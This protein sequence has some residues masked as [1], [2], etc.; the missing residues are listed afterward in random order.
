M[1]GLVLD[2]LAVGHRRGRRRPAAAVLAGVDARAGAG[3]LTVLVG[4]NGT[5]KSTLLHTVAGLLPPLAGTVRVDGA[6]VAELPPAERARR[7]AVVLTERVE[8]GL[9]AVEELVALGRHPHTGPTG[10][11]GAADRAAVAAAIEAAGAGH[12]AGRRVVELS[13]GERQ[14]VL[15]ARALAQ[16]PAVLLLDEPTAFLDVSSRVTLLDVLRGL[17]REAGLCVLVSTHDLEPALRLADHAWLL[18]R[19]GRL[20]AGPPE[21]LV[22]DGAVAEVFD[23][24]GLA[25]DP[26]AGTF[27]LRGDGGGPPVAVVAPEPEKAL[28]ARLLARE[29]CAVAGELAQDV[30]ATVTLTGPGRFAVS[31]DGGGNGR[32]VE[33]A[34]WSELAAW[35]RRAGVAP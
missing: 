13:D 35:A 23:A 19:T 7:V 30:A 5:G 21:Q 24:P 2:G 28:V 4:P 31:A 6:D 26:A 20:R 27:V 18:D 12:L 34:G 16:E 1:N 14:R 10:A 32:A 29:G 8:P 9:L 17:A 33:L 3:E 15:T 11:L 22:A 25:F